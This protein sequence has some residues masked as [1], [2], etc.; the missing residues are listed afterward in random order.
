[1]PFGS[2]PAHGLHGVFGGLRNASMVTAG[3]PGRTVEG[4]GR[5]PARRGRWGTRGHTVQ[6]GRRRPSAPM[7]PSTAP[8]ITRQAGLCSCTSS[9]VDDPAARPGLFPRLAVEPAHVKVES[10]FVTRIQTCSWRRNGAQKGSTTFAAYAWR[11]AVPR[12]VSA[13]IRVCRVVRCCGRRRRSCWWLC[14]WPRVPVRT[15]RLR[16]RECPRGRAARGRRPLVRPPHRQRRPCRPP[17]SG[18][19][20]VRFRRRTASLE[21]GTGPLG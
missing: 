12:G 8:H 14:S 5:T 15:A 3:S 2:R 13:R 16:I 21:R 19:A 18:R 20:S 11:E 6:P 1:M 9:T 7:M 10:P 17:R 4:P